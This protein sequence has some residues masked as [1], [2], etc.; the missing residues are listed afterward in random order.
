[1]NTVCLRCLVSGRVQG[2]WFRGAT[3]D[4][5]RE[6][7]ISGYAENLPDGRVEVLAHGRERAVADFVEW[8]WQGPPMARVT[9]VI[10]EDV[11]PAV[12]LSGFQVR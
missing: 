7:G 6:L 5:A 8:L 10:R 11:E 1:V 4:K 3:R 9:D 12:E 2:V